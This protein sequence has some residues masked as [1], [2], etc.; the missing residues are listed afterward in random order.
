MFAVF[1]LSA[2]IYGRHGVEQRSKEC[3][4]TVKKMAACL[5]L[6]LQ[7]IECALTHSANDICV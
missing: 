6:E 1:G 2:C 7:Q 4:L 5:S 3:D